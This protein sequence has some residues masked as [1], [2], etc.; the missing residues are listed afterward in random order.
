MRVR[1]IFIMILLALLTACGQPTSRFGEVANEPHEHSA[2]TSQDH[3]HTP[4]TTAS[5]L[6]PVVA[7]SELVVG[8]N[9]MALGLLENNIPIKDAA[10]TRVHVRYYKLN[11]EQATL[12]GEEDAT[13]YGDGLGPQGT[14]IVYPVFDT[15]GLWGM[16]VEV[17][18]PSQPAVT[19]RL[20]L[21]VLAKGNAPMIGAPAPRSKTPT[22]R[23]VSDLRMIS[24]DSE[25][26][27]R[28]Y[29]IS[30]A[31]AV[32]SGKP[33]L[34][35]FATPGY[36]QTAVCGPGVD[37]VSRLAETFGDKINAV[38]VEIYQYPFEELKPVAAMEEWG[39]RTE[40]WLFLVDR[41]GKIAGRYEGGITYA[42]LEPEVAKLVR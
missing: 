35:L 19:E 41:N 24:S 20:S 8:P 40:P 5:K 38:H 4:T 30:V 15:A 18:R 33:S 37:V 2:D 11:G 7:T 31:E 22:A 25:P 9:R 28:L 16:E 39:L 23:D 13:Y 27:P 10:D 6:Q 34:I 36:C 32:G 14:F 1:N 26:D 29:Q 12:V 42:E 3:S 21:N 17:E